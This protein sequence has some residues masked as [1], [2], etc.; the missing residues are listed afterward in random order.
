MPVVDIPRA[1][2]RILQKDVKLVEFAHRRWSA[3]LQEGQTLDEALVPEF[4]SDV[5]RGDQRGMMAG[6]VVELRSFDHSFFAE[7]YVRKVEQGSATVALIRSTDFIDRKAE[8]KA[9]AAP[10]AALA[11]RWNPGRQCFEVIRSSD[12]EVVSTGHKLKEDAKAW[13]ETHLRALKAA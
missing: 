9:E 1:R 4:W 7:I 3:A 2:K 6:D 5:A 10:H 11:T 13:I 12:K 8:A